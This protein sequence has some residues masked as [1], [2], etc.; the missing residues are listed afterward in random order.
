MKNTAI[1]EN[2]VMR[3]QQK[4]NKEYTIKNDRGY[5]VI[6]III[7]IYLIL[8]VGVFPLFFTDKY[9]NIVQSKRFFFEIVTIGF[10]VIM[11]FAFI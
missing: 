1:H 4:K 6:Q 8:M 7:N 9:I 5:N 11:A 2:G 3:K 10:I